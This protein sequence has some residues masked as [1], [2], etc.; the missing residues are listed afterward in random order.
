VGEAQAE[1]TESW[2]PQP[3]SRGQSDFPPKEE[4]RFGSSKLREAAVRQVRVYRRRVWRL[5]LLALV[6]AVITSGSGTA[7][8]AYA[9]STITVDCIADPTAL[10]TA[11]AGATDGDTLAI[12][13]TCKGTFEIAH[14]LTLAGSSGATLD[15]QRARTVL[16][17]DTGNTAAITNLTITGGNGSTAGGILN[18]GTVTLTD[19]TVSGNSAT[20][21][22]FPNVGGGGIFNQAGSVTLTNSTVSGNSASVGSVRN[23]AGGIVSSGG[24]LTLTNSTVSGNSATSDA[25]FSTAIGGIAIGAF[26]GPASLTLTGSTVSGNSASALSDAFGGIVD[27]APGA[28]V[29]VTNSTV[30]GNS[31]SATGGTSAFSS[32]VGGISNSGGSLSLSSVTLAGNSVSEP[33]GGFLPPVGGVSNFFDG[34]LTA[35]NSLIAGQSGGPNCYG[36][37]ASSDGGYN[38]DDGSSCGFSSLS[39]S[40]SSTDPLLDAAGLRDN[41]GPTET[42]ALQ[43]GSPA[44][45]AIP[46]AVNGCGTTITTDQRG[47]SRPQGTGCDI[48]AFEVVPPAGADLSITKSGVPNPVVSGDRLTYTLTV[49]NHGPQDATGVTVTDPLPGNVHFDSVASNRGSCTRS[50]TKPAPKG[51]TVSCNLGDLANGSTASITIVV[52]T[53]TS[54]VLTNTAT[55]AGNETDPDPLNNSGTATTKVIGT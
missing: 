28:V 41:G 2:R 27:S 1:I 51:G 20:P 55:V 18:S 12:Q 17:V 25:S 19:S 39:N 7:K 53:T 50:T 40:L 21:G 8:P 54:G 48:G 22:T 14:S 23:G 43:P 26:G 16:T 24:S 4:R 11:L 13:G 36:L 9:A 34:T 15:G 49:T 44:I 32:A 6:S 3:G 47:A 5:T 30:S 31:A 52:T 33:N 46:A 45:D 10:S 38:L 29:A 35:Q 42:I 37:A